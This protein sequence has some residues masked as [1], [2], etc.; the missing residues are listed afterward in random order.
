MIVVLL[1]VIAIVGGV[2]IGLANDLLDSL[3]ELQTTAPDAA[4]GLEEQFD[5][6][7]DIGVGDRVQAFVDELNDRIH[8][9]RRVPVCRDR[10]D[11]PRHRHLDAVP[12]QLR[13]AL[14]RRLRGSVPARIAATTS[15]RS[16]QPARC[17]AAATS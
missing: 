3:D 1:G 17:A 11:V 6:A 10:A 4:A 7:A 16:P 2:T 15:E 14:L 13:P 8:E 5:W 9:P 12:P